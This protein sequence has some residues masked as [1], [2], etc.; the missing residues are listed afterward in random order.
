[1]AKFIYILRNYGGQDLA[2]FLK[3]LKEHMAI[4]VTSDGGVDK[5]QADLNIDAVMAFLDKQRRDL[6]DFAAA[7]DTKDPDL[8]NASG[9]AIKFSRY[10][11]L[12]ADCDSLGTELKNLPASETVH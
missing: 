7:V 4:K 10:M 5:L 12:D 1:M 6:F 2:E 11:D 3:D 9:T 8:G